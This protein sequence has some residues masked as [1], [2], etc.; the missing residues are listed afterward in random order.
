MELMAVVLLTATRI[1]AMVCSA[2]VL[3]HHQVGWWIRIGLSV[4]LSVLALS[5]IGPQSLKVTLNQTDL[6][7]AF[8]SEAL[9]GLMLGLGISVLLAAG[10]LM[11]DILAQ[12]SG[13]NSGGGIEDEADPAP[14]NTRLI[15]IVTI[16]M[17]VL[18]RGPEQLASGVLDSL[19][20]IPIGSRMV[21]SDGLEFLGELITQ[22]FWLA[23]RGVGPA[24]AAMFAAMAI[25][26]L[27]QKV[28]PQTGVVH[29]GPTVGLLVMALAMWITLSGGLW[30][31]DGNWQ[32][33]W[34]KMLHFLAADAI[35]DAPTVSMSVIDGCWNGSY[36]ATIA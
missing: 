21:R 10:E 8:V 2:P 33:G 15:G 9:I 35:S 6:F 34:E 25:V 19:Q 5:S 23:L 32:A 28:L 31:I 30:L 22:S 29:A 27:I 16:A 13:M 11:G 3:G 26:S 17:F 20:A 36:R 12:L 7:G 24:V 18:A 14:A 1:T 4:A